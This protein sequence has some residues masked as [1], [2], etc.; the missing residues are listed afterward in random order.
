V[1]GTL[2]VAVAAVAAAIILSSGGS[3]AKAELFEA[4]LRPVPDNH[5]TGNG[6]AAVRLQ[7]NSITVTVD[8]AGLLNGAPH[9][10]H[11]HAFGEGICPPP[12]AA[13]L[14]NGH[15]AIS[16]TDGIKYFG[17]MAVAL[18]LGGDTSPN[19][20]LAFPRYPT[21]GNIHYQ[22]TIAISPATANAIRNGN[23]V[24]VVHGIDY[25]HSGHY[26]NVLSRSELDS[27]VPQEE[28]APAL[29]G[30]LVNPQS[31]GESG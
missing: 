29:C 7:G 10:M 11:I 26:D 14:Y 30:T 15:L 28:T 3:A 18:T 1:I 8:T 17:P 27:A 6:T 23:A 25:D 13:R 5:V 4:I 20:M 2:A 24:V 22:R 12:S 21:T 19:S 16:T 9:A 31:V